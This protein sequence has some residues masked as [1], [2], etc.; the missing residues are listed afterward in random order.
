MKT[1]AAFANP[2]IFWILLLG[3]SSG[4]PLAL[5]G[6]TLQAWMQAEGVDLGTIGVFSLVGLPYTLKYLWAPL[7]DRFVPPFLGRRRGWMLVAQAGLAVAVSA[8][9]FSDP[10][11]AT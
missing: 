9:A 2:R 3:F 4:V 1:L 7:M 11:A 8:M 10:R 5:T 6:T